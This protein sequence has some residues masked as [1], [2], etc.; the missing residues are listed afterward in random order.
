MWN[1]TLAFQTQ[2]STSGKSEEIFKYLPKSSPLTESYKS[3]DKELVLNI[4]INK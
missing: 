2:Y 4:K 3:D 1:V